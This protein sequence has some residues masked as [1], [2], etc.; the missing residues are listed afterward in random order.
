MARF[1]DPSL[2][3]GT[4]HGLAEQIEAKSHKPVAEDLLPGYAGDKPLF[5]GHYWLTGEPEPLNQY[6]VC[7]DFSIAAGHSRGS[8]EGKLC[9][10]RWD[11]EQVLSK[12]R[13]VWVTA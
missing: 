12:D 8:D 11:G 7:L 2:C 3:Q 6:I 13:F 9:A 5:V 1:R 10:Y 4:T